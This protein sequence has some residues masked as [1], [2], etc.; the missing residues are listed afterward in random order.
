MHVSCMA[1]SPR[2]ARLC[3]WR[4]STSVSPGGAEMSCRIVFV[5]R[6][7]SGTIS[8]GI[9]SGSSGSSGISGMIIRNW[10]TWQS[11]VAWAWDLSISDL[12][13]TSSCTQ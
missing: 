12:S 7:A 10:Q 8:I 11:G 13:P 3:P 5:V 4:R 9:G 1:Y 6:L 2:L